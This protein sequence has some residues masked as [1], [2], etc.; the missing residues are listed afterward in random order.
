[1]IDSVVISTQGQGL[2][3]FTPAVQEFITA[4]LTQASIG[5]PITDGAPAFGV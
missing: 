3:E 5:V 4:A 2:Y 1:M